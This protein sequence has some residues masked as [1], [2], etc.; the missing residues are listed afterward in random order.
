MKIDSIKSNFYTSRFLIIIPLAILYFLVARWSLLLAFPGSNASPV[1]PPSGIALGIMLLLGYRIWPAIFLGAFLA[2]VSLLVVGAESWSNITIISC[3]L[4][5]I[6]NTFEAIAAVWLINNFKFTESILSYPQN[7][8]KFMVSVLLACTIAASFGIAS[9]YLAGLLPNNIA[10]TVWMNWWLG[11]VA[12][13]LM[14]TPFILVWLQNSYSLIQKRSLF[15]TL[16][17][18]ILM[19]GLLSIIFSGYFYKNHYDRLMLIPLMAAIFCIANRYGHIGVTLSTIF[20]AA[21]AVWATTHNL[22]P[23]ASANLNNAL[24]LLVTVI[25]IT[26]L[27]GLVLASDKLQNPTFKKYPPASWLT[28]F[29]SLSLT[30]LI[31]HL[32]SLTTEFQANEKFQYKVKEVKSRIEQRLNVYE[33]LLESG[34]ALFAAS[35][36]VERDEWKK[37]YGQLNIISNYPGVQGFGFAKYLQSKD[38]DNFIK[39]TRKEGFPDFKVMPEGL[40]DEYII[41]QYLEPFNSINKN[42]FGYDMNSEPIMRKSIQE[43][44]DNGGATLSRKV[45]LLKKN[46]NDI[47]SGFFMYM[48]VYQNG[49]QPNSVIHLQQALVGY[50]FCSFRTANFIDEAIGNDFNNINL[51]IYDGEKLQPENILYATKNSETTKSGKFLFRAQSKIKA[52]N[53]LWSLSVISAPS[54]QAS[55]DRSKEQI[56]LVAGFL[57]SLLL[58]MHVRGLTLT[59]RSA[60]LLAKQMTNALQGAEAKFGSLAESANEGI[61]VADSQGRIVYCNKASSKIFGY[62]EQEMISQN[63]TRIMPERFHSLHNQGMSRMN[64]GGEAKVIGRLVELVG[65]TKNGVEFPLELSLSTWQSNEDKFYG[66]IIH[67]IS[68]RKRVEFDLR[69]LSDRLVVA[70]E[71]VEAGI[72]DWDIQNNTLN[73]D[74]RMHEFYQI[75][76]TIDS[77]IFKAWEVRLHPNCAARVA[78][79]LNESIETGKPFKSE[80]SLLLPNGDVRNIRARALLQKDGHGRAWHLV[81]INLDITE[82]KLKEEALSNSEQRFRNTLEHA[83]IGMALV[84]PEGRWLECNGALCNI[85]GYSSQELMTMTFQDITHPDD[86]D[87][88]LTKVRELLDNQIQSYQIQKRYLHKDGRIVWVL[89]AVCFMRDAN[90]KPLYFISQI[91]NIDVLKSA[92]LKLKE[93][94]RR[95]R[96]LI[97]GVK[98]YA[99]YMIDKTGTVLT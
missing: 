45:A 68:E 41:I 37:F 49:T 44:R 23:F 91:E 28:L 8:F 12:G 35:K 22:G 69:A 26:S 50:V 81:G 20:I 61:V 98:D 27:V 6:G 90:H 53:H 15:E 5:A 87:A 86:L 76:P 93:S 89:L 52:N 17:T 34:V 11:D 14:I 18:I 96:L 31:W 97:D 59:R 2:N 84:S 51:E 54:F 46:S 63:L 48:P 56:I 57:I 66:A 4:I 73:C 70:T 60:E 79:E 30:I 72:W 58:F 1:W 33:Q 40:R 47:E 83:P 64:E 94:E 36:T 24:I 99:I 38:K 21:I 13:I 32:V 43:T 77:T 78:L 7:I 19:L 55:I 92:E 9:L 95:F 3:L 80:F 25:A 39:L 29:A 74:V 16:L 42:G 85:I 82:E 75:E 67:D 71:A 10:L 65:L 62:T 88:D